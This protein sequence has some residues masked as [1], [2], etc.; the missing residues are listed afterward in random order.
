MPGARISFLFLL[1]VVALCVGGCREKGDITIKSITFNGV[2]QIDKKALM[3]ALATKQGS[4]LP[5]GRKSY[6]DRR[7][8][9]ADLQ[10]I[11]VP[12]HHL[13]GLQAVLQR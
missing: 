7:A 6:F 10:R 13:P 2:K 9:E 1:L 8:F 11:H 4:R 3:N 5:W 12:R